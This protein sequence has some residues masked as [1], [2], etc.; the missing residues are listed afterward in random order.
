M[1]K[2]SNRQ[3]QEGIYIYIIRSIKYDHCSGTKRR[4]IYIYNKIK[5]D[6]CMEPKE[7]IY[8]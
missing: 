1:G 2:S 3:K 6:H 5:Y 4:Y 8:I 7:Y